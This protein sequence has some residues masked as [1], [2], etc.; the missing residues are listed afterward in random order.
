[1][2]LG[3]VSHARP[4]LTFHPL[5]V[6]S[7]WPKQEI[8]L[9]C[10]QLQQHVDDYDPTISYHHLVLRC[11]QFDEDAA[12]WNVAPMVYAQDTSVNGTVLTREC[13]AEDGSIV[14]LD[15]KLTKSMGPVLLQDGDCL[16]FSKSTFVQY[17]QMRPDNNFNMS[18]IMDSEVKRFQEEFT[19]YPRLISAGGQGKVFL[20]WDR[21]AGQQ[22][23]CKAVSLA[24]VDL[25]RHQDAPNE[26]S[27]QTVPNRATRMKSIKLLR[28]IHSLEVEYEV[29]K[30]L[31]HP[32][33]IDMRKV[34]ITTHHIYIIQ[35]LMA[36]GDLFSYINYKGGLLRDTS[37]AVITRQLLKAVEYLHNNGVVHRDIKPENILMTSWHPTTRVVL[38]DFGL[39]KQ[40]SRSSV[41]TSQPG[42]VSRMFSSCGTYGFSAPEINRLNPFMA[43]KKGYSSAIDLWS[44]GCVSALMLTGSLAFNHRDGDQ[45]IGQINSR[46]V[47]AYDLTQIDQG[48]HSW[49]GVSERARKLVRSLLVLQEEKRSTAKQ[50]LEHPW[51]TNDICAPSYDAVYARSIND[52]KPGTTCKEDV[53]V[54]IDTSDIAMPTPSASQVIR[55]RSDSAVVQSE[56]FRAQEEG[57]DDQRDNSST[58]GRFSEHEPDDNLLLAASP[59]SQQSQNHERPATLSDHHSNNVRHLENTE[60]YKIARSWL[61][62]QSS[63]FSND[64]DSLRP[65][66]QIFPP[67]SS[68]PDQDLDSLKPSAQLK[69]LQASPEFTWPSSPPNKRNMRLPS[70]G[71]PWQ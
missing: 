30:D 18:F 66:V 1:M 34:L 3:T 19:I 55:Q 21:N 70:P 56:F 46:S 60:S 63:D 12:T 58:A 44:V 33:I 45:D 22:V 50:A 42:R 4:F 47:S 20:A 5:D 8:I 29:L 67:Q 37:S 40:I 25:S 27:M 68:D 64:L 28:K 26:A 10:R 7:V 9:G 41:S 2:S 62:P 6:I 49:A 51:F 54:N 36:G 53:V 52:W 17:S 61:A 69:R 24:G 65:S 23:A 32:N 43:E 35:E 39:A 48:K 71:F 38:T 57:D 16:Y 13:P 15:H 11:V 31:S 14:L 59:A